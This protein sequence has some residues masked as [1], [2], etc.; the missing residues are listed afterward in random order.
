MGLSLSQAIASVWWPRNVGATYLCVI[1]S[2]PLPR[3]QL[4]AGGRQDFLWPRPLLHLGRLT[5]APAVQ[6]WPPPSPRPVSG[7]GS[8]RGRWGCWNSGS[9]Q[10][11]GIVRVSSCHSAHSHLLWGPAGEAPVAPSPH[12]SQGCSEALSLWWDCWPPRGYQYPG[13]GTLA[14]LFPQGAQWQEYSE[15]APFPGPQPILS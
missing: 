5:W 2:A 8:L 9:Q 14:Y 3:L 15:N 6:A 1:R 7:N 11:E 13:L 4:A 12:L 10:E